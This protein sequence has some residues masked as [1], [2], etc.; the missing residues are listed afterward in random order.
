MDILQGLPPA[1]AAQVLANMNS[2]GEIAPLLEHAEESA[3]GGDLEELRARLVQVRLTEAPPGIE[4][5]EEAALALERAIGSSPRVASP[6][7]LDTV[8]AA[9]RELELALGEAGSSPF[10]QAMRQGVEAVELFVRDVE[11]GYKLPVG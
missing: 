8:G 2:A 5:A 6:A 4:E 11:A 7:Y 9:T 1:E 10:A 3:G